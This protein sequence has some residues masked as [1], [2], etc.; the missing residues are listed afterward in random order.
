MTIIHTPDGT[1]LIT[2]PDLGTISRR[3]LEEAQAEIRR[4]KA[5]EKAS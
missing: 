3:T 2:L 1:V 5:M 4:L